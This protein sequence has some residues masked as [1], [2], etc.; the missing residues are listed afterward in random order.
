MSAHNHK[1]EPSKHTKIAHISRMRSLL[2]KC[3]VNDAM[4]LTKSVKKHI[5]KLD[6]CKIAQRTKKNLVNALMV[7]WPCDK[8]V[9]AK[10]QWRK[11]LCEVSC[12]IKRLEAC[13]NMPVRAVVNSFDWGD[14]T[15]KRLELQK[16]LASFTIKQHMMWLVLAVYEF[17]PPKRSDLGQV[18]LVRTSR[19]NKNE[20]NIN[21]DAGWLNLAHYKTQ[22][23]YGRY[24]EKL[25]PELI[26][27]IKL[28]LSICPRRFLFVSSA[29]NPLNACEYGRLVRCAFLQFMNKDVN[30]CILRHMFIT[31]FLGNAPGF[32]RRV[33]AR[34]MLHSTRLQEQYR[35]VAGGHNEL[36]KRF[37]IKE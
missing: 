19:I 6:A 1:I 11:Y 28:S 8:K 23:R 20:N 10:K 33:A 9:A 3:G 14:I 15:K 27:L 31:Q 25:R 13:N 37:M 17:I 30:V 26:E 2:K 12:A 32:I 29:M 34:R 22:K 24:C 4:E 16:N 5:E 36:K 7:C 18:R 35:Y 21:L